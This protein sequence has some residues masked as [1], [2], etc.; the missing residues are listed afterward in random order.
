MLFGQAKDC[1]FSIKAAPDIGHGSLRRIRDTSRQSHL[2]WLTKN[3]SPAARRVI[4]GRFEAI[5]DNGQYTVLS[6]MDSHG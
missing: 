6:E 1:R 5:A 4:V 3:Q 2:P